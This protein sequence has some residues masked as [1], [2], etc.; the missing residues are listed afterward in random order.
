MT[1]D[2]WNEFVE[3]DVLERPRLFSEGEPSRSHYRARTPLLCWGFV[4]VDLSKA[5]LLLKRS[6]L[7]LLL[8]PLFPQRDHGGV[9][10]V[11]LMW[12]SAVVGAREERLVLV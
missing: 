10:V 8:L 2:G 5:R 9:R 4:S 12:S 11:L 3:V 1:L 7:A 6:I